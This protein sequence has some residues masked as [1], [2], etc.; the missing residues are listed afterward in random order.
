[1]KKSFV[2]ILFATIIITFGFTSFSESADFPKKPIR[3]VVPFGPGGTHDIAA[4]IVDGVLQE[5]LEVPVIHVNKSG[6]GG[7]VGGGYAKQQKADGYTLLYGGL[8]VLIEA[9]IVKPN[10]TYTWRDF[11]PLARV[12]SGPLVLSVRK[13]SPWNSLEDYIAA[14]KKS[15]GK[16]TL[17]VPSLT[18][19][20]YLVASLFQK[21]AGI[22]LNVIPFKGD[23]PNITA[24]LG[25]HTDSAMTGLTS[26]TPHLNAGSVKPFASSSPD[27]HPV[28]KDIPTFKEKG[29]PKI[30]LLSWTGAW[31][32]KGTPKDRVKILEEA[33]RKAANHKSVRT[34]I[35][36][37][38]STPDYADTSALMK[39]V[40]IE[41]EAIRIAVEA[42]GIKK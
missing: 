28:Q 30:A 7:I 9:P 40:P 19:S 20:Q 22:K 36:K 18:G 32:R 37:A 25:K 21:L 16:V 29:F 6:G 8:S 1:M 42:A 15:P 5:V 26:L 4:R 14:A 3:V 35:K 10:A 23:G 27:R 38:G 11:I 2:F 12:T 39:I 17:G 33:Y 41:E 34:L 31:V 13:D 24:L